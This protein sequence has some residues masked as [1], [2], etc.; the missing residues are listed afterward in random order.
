MPFAIAVPPDRTRSQARVRQ[1]IP[2][3]PRAG[4]YRREREAG[5][6]I[7]ASLAKLERVIHEEVSLDPL[8][9]M[10]VAHYQFEAM[11][12]FTDVAAGR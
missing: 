6:D 11:Y 12:T 1:R 2:V 5:S 10:A 9:C 3:G 4:M 8:M 7:Q